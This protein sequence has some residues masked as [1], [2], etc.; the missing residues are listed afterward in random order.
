[1]KASHLAK[2]SSSP[3]IQFY[4]HLCSI[5]WASNLVLDLKRLKRVHLFAVIT[6]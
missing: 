6:T 3:L 2:L 4:F 5:A 1:M